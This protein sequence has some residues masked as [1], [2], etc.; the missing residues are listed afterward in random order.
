M[1]HYGI[2]IAADNA[3]FK[4]C[5][6]IADDRNVIVNGQERKIRHL[7]VNVGVQAFFINRIAKGN[8]V[9]LTF[10]NHGSFLPSDCFS[11]KGFRY[12]LI[13]F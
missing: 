4:P 5:N 7:R 13:I 3:A 12:N 2:C 8:A 6:N 1:F 10:K 11:V 9:S